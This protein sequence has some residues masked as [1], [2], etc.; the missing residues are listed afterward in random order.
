VTA[1]F[2]IAIINYNNPLCRDGRTGRAR[3]SYEILATKRYCITI[4]VA[5]EGGMG[6]RAMRV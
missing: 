5:K 3:S 1:D 6:D 4:F 2:P